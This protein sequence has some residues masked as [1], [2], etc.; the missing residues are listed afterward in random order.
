MDLKQNKQ[1]VL[2]VS[3]KIVALSNFSWREDTPELVNF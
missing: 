2:V 3:S 1:Y